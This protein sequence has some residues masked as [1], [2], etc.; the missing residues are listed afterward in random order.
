MPI[1]MDSAMSLLS[2]SEISSFLPS[3]ETVHGLVGNP[4]DQ[5]SRIAA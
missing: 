5:F 1:Y 2:I 3:S 4:E